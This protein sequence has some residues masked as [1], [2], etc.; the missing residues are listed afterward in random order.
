MAAAAQHPVPAFTEYVA[1]VADAWGSAAPN[2]IADVATTARFPHAAGGWRTLAVPPYADLVVSLANDPP[3][4]TNGLYKF[5]TDGAFPVRAPGDVV[6]DELLTTSTALPPPIPHSIVLGPAGLANPIQA[7]I[8]TRFPRGAGRH[9]NYAPQGFLGPCFR[10]F[11]TANQLGMIDT[12]RLAGHPYSD[13]ALQAPLDAATCQIARMYAFLTLAKRQAFWAHGGDVK[14]IPAFRQ[15]HAF[16][17]SPF[18]VYLE[19]IC[20]PHKNNVR[21]VVIAELVVEALR[22]LCAAVPPSPAAA[23]G[24]PA[25]NLERLHLKTYEAGPGQPQ[26]PWLPAACTVGGIAVEAGDGTLKPIACRPEMLFTYNE[27]GAGEVLWVCK[28]SGADTDTD[29]AQAVQNAVAVYMH[30]GGTRRVRA[31]LITTVSAAPADTYTVSG[32][33]G[34]S[35]YTTKASAVLGRAEIAAYYDSLVT[36]AKSATTALDVYYHNSQ[37]PA[38]RNQPAQQ[39]HP[40]FRA[41]GPTVTLRW[42]NSLWAG[43]FI[44]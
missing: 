26:Q 41:C 28:L 34:A 19:E 33:W 10:D 16:K 25:D 44:G 11:A 38:R 9:R 3:A 14:S 24:A 35:T 30:Y 36:N 17:Q 31:I 20:M 6:A 42:Q 37:R 2:D 18:G 27:A 7:D 40:N 39:R 1:N 22:A 23:G 12:V 32:D 8:T 5:S 21:V 29:W 15:I 13:A 43:V 4:P